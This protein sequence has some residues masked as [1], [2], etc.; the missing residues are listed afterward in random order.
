MSIYEKDPE[1]MADMKMKLAAAAMPIPVR[2]SIYYVV[3]GM[4]LTS[5]LLAVDSAEQPRDTPTR[6]PSRSYLRDV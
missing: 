2:P 6:A 5:Y 3:F 1:T 4:Y